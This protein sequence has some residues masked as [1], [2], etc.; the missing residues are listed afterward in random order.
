MASHRLHA[1][2]AA[3]KRIDVASGEARHVDA[4]RER[5]V[6]DAHRVE[7]F[8]IVDRER[9]DTTAPV[10]FGFDEPFALEHAHGFAQ[11]SAADA[12]LAGELHLGQAI[13]RVAASRSES[14]RAG[15]CRRSRSCRAF[16]FAVAPRRFG[17]GSECGR[18][19]WKGQAKSRCGSSITSASM[20]GTKTIRV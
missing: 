15:W 7:L 1:A 19:G 9:G 5:L 20:T 16:S 6:D 17:G 8:E 4:D 12:E 10:D 14:T 18:L 11:R 3:A 2:Q 13:R